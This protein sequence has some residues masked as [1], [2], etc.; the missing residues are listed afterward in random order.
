MIAQFHTRSLCLVSL[1]SVLACA[2]ANPIDDEVVDIAAR[3]AQPMPPAQPR[4]GVTTRHERRAELDCYRMTV[5]GD[6]D[7][8]S[9]KFLVGAPFASIASF[10]F[11]APW[12]GARTI[13][14]ITPLLDGT[15]VH[16][17]FLYVNVDKVGVQ[18][19]A[20]GANPGADLLLAW[21]RASDVLA[22]APSDGIPVKSGALLGIEHVYARLDGDAVGDASGV[23]VCVT[24]AP[25]ERAVGT[26]RLGIEAFRGNPITAR[27]TPKLSQPVTIQPVLAHTRARG[28]SVSL[29]HTRPDGSEATLFDGP[30]NVV[31]PLDRPA[32]AAAT[33]L[34]PGSA[35][36]VTC[37][38]D[39]VVMGSGRVPP[40]EA[41]DVLAL[42]SPPGAIVADLFEQL[43][44]GNNTCMDY[45]RQP[46][47]EAPSRAAAP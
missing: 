28:R 19:R 26:V 22:L 24:A 40:Y 46:A 6:V 16:R 9:T 44:F 47:A 45:P 33:T 27:C 30:P 43:M 11:R 10:R 13:K 36:R 12:E 29:V 7:A 1:C 31:Q 39:G 5:T 8:A 2:D 4:A 23:E 14:S 35:L 15:L 34:E 37:N 20:V 32:G 25:P 21:T 42:V 3:V 38:Y 17:G 41:C 18:T